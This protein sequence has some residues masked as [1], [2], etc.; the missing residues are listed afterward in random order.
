MSLLLCEI[1][2][3]AR[4]AEATAIVKDVT[5]RKEFLPIDRG[6]LSE[7]AGKHFLAVDLIYSD[8]QKK[9]ALVGLPVEADS[10]AHRI[11]VKLSSIH[12]T[13]EIGR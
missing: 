10:G 1:T 11:W 9:I 8:S 6:L 7:E 3:G 5:G 2:E 12:Q 13:S 4:K